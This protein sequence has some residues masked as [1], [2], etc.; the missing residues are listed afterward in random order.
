MEMTRVFFVFLLF[1]PFA[2][3]A[4][5][6]APNEFALV[7]QTDC[8]LYCTKIPDECGSMELVTDATSPDFCM[9]VWKGAYSRTENNKIITLG[10]AVFGVLAVAGYL[11]YRQRKEKERKR[12]VE[13]EEKTRYDY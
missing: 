5:P 2:T 9:C 13:E 7:N 8:S 6:P 4:C 3:A 10:A 11:A 12:L 1:S